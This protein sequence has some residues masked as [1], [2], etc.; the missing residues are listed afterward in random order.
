MYYEPPRWPVRSP[1]GV[2]KGITAASAGQAAL[3]L[4]SR[5]GFAG[6]YQIG[7]TRYDCQQ[8]G[9]GWNGTVE[10]AVNHSP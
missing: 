3:T 7:S 6:V 8:D 9:I 10:F 4:A 5:L 2:M 1:L